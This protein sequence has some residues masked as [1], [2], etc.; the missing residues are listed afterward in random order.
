MLEAFL[1]PMHSFWQQGWQQKSRSSYF[2]RA[3]F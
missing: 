1:L 2:E 3:A